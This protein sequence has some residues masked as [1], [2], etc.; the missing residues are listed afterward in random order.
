MVASTLPETVEGIKQISP[1]SLTELNSNLADF[2]SLAAKV[3]E[4]KKET[5]EKES[6]VLVAILQRITP[7]IPILTDESEPYQRRE[8]II[9]TDET[10]VPI[11]SN[12][13]FYSEKKL[14]LYENGSLI[15]S[16]RYGESSKALRLGWELTDM[17]ELTPQIAISCF[18]LDAIAVGIIRTLKKAT[19]MIIL[20]EELEARLIEL[21][22]ILAVLR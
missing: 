22:R 18:G 8:L 7:L 16:H 20:T 15:R 6:Q 12:A 10:A 19:E 2:E 5:L 13:Q 9:I 21:T 17:L 14:I 1:L 3:T 11:D 4:L